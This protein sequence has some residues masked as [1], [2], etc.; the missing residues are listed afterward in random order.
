MGTVEQVRQQVIDSIKYWLEKG[1]THIHV[2]N[3]EDVDVPE[4]L[5]EEEIIMLNLS[6][7]F[8]DM[9]FEDDALHARLTFK[10]KKHHCVIPYDQIFYIQPASEEEMGDFITENLPKQLFDAANVLADESDEA[11]AAIEAEEA[12]GGSVINFEEWV[13]KNK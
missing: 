8:G 10:G 7:L 2:L 9:V 5:R 11:I 13:K 4:Y 12:E 6:L 3:S 1:M